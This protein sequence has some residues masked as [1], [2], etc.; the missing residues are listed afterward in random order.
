[1]NI[2]RVNQMFVWLT[3]RGRRCP[4]IRLAHRLQESRGWLLLTHPDLSHFPH[5]I[6]HPL[7]T[8]CLLLP[9]PP[10]FRS[11]QSGCPKSV[12]LL[13]LVQRSRAPF[14]YV[15]FDRASSSFF[16]GAATFLSDLLTARQANCTNR[17]FLVDRK[18]NMSDRRPM[19]CTILDPKQ[20]VRVNPVITR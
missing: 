2:V 13:H 6:L 8:H 16:S 20:E 3:P 19:Q 5:R 7:Q 15:S 10:H 12:E 18:L 14:P 4:G 9:T 11:L 1:M 17:S